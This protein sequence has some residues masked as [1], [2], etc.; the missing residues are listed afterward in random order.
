[1]NIRKLNEICYTYQNILNEIISDNY[2]VHVLCLAEASYTS[3]HSTLLV[4]YNSLKA[5]MRHDIKM[6]TISI[7][8]KKF[9]QQMKNQQ[10]N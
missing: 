3:D 2:I 5:E 10:Y 7:T 9:I 8:K 6:S 1:M 4:I